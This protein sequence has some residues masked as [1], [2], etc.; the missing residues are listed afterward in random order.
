MTTFQGYT[1]VSTGDALFQIDGEGS[2]DRFDVEAARILPVGFDYL[3]QDGIVIASSN[4][5]DH[6]ILDQFN[7]T[8]ILGTESS[9]IQRMSAFLSIFVDE[10]E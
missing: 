1:W 4:R 10:D 9:R 6:Y 7:L 5:I 3:E 8:S 2:V